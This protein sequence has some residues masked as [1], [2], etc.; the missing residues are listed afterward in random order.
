MNLS[1]TIVLF[2]ITISLFTSTTIS[3]AE[4]TEI[5]SPRKQMKNGVAAEDVICKSSFTLMIRI[6]GDAV[7]VKPSTAEKLTSAGFGT[8][9]K[10]ASMVKEPEIDKEIPDVSTDQM[11]DHVNSQD[12]IMGKPIHTDFP[13]IETLTVVHANK[14]DPA[15]FILEYEITA[16]NKKLNAIHV[17]VHSDIETVQSEI[18]LL[19]PNTKG[20]QYVIINANDPASITA[21]IESY[22]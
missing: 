1:L 13:T 2:A 18:P 17:S 5:D 10:E 12:V 6:S 16:G 8:I 14:I 21:Q 3:F 19:E 11:E 15:T 7:C 9:E 22:N 4:N 20:I